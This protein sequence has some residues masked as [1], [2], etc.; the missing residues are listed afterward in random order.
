MPRW[1]FHL[2]ADE[3]GSAARWV[4]MYRPDGDDAITSRTTFATYRD[5]INDAL[6]HGY[7]PDARQYGEHTLHASG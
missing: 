1:E 5:C 7:R 2:S 6:L 3:T 4:W